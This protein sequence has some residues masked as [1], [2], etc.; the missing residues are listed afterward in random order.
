M[1]DTNCTLY[2]EQ[3]ENHDEGEVQIKVFKRKTQSR[4]L[5]GLVRFASLE[6]AVNAVA[7]VNH[8]LIKPPTSSPADRPYTLK[9]CF[10]TNSEFVQ[11][12]P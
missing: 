12:L 5:S 8:A 9:L 6:S 7:R 10:S 1:N 11:G 3:S 2:F 4:T